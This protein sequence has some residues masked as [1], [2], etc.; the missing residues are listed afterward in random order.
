MLYDGRIFFFEP[1]KITPTPFNFFTLFRSFTLVVN[2][3]K[4]HRKL[5]WTLCLIVKYKDC[6]NQTP[7]APALLEDDNR[8]ENT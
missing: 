1:L 8:K 3:N 5:V 6:S 4:S 2:Y 7:C